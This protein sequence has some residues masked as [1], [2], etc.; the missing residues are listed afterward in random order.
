MNKKKLPITLG[1]IVKNEAR[2]LPSC[3]ETLSQR[4]KEIIVVD[5]GSK[6][7]T[8]HLA[9]QYGARLIRFE[10]KEFHYGKA[11]NVYLDYA[12]Q[13]W[14]LSLDA[15]ERISEIDQRRLGKLLKSKDVH[16]YHFWIRNYNDEFNLLSDWYPNRGKYPEEERTAG[17]H[18][19]FRTSDLRLFRNDLRF[20]YQGRV[21]ASVKY[22]ICHH[23]GII[24]TA[25]FPIHH[26]ECLKGS[27][28]ILRKQR[29][30]V[31]QTSKELMD[32][33][34]FAK[35]YL[36]VGIGLFSLKRGDKKAI[37]HLRKCLR[38]KPG[39]P[40]A[41]KYLGMIFLEN[42]NMGSAIRHLRSALLRDSK[43]A[44]L[45]CLLGLA[46]LRQG[47][48]QGA[49]AYLQDALR[50]HK[51]HAVATH[52][53]GRAYEYLGKNRM[54]FQSYRQALRILPIYPPAVKDLKRIRKK[55]LKKP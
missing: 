50:Y 25:P 21:H 40:D 44:D 54:A 43:N 29:N 6:D 17:T 8:P 55:I 1:L 53:K 14:I 11:R 46:F 26:F 2:F 31:R 47:R 15:D 23:R 49:L 38:I 3:L 13:P 10:S 42:D 19:W 51:D 27:R 35:V 12:T 16:G 9:S 39:H 37:S 36:D 30:Y 41:H 7:K 5:T 18:G 48:Y 32:S 24:R 52:L 45:H 4:V 34:D 33:P 20:R 28:F 22:S